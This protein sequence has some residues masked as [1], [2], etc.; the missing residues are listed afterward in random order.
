M[1]LGRPRRIDPRFSV[2]SRNSHAVLSPR[3]LVRAD[4]DWA[5]VAIADRRDPGCGN[6]RGDK[7]VL[8]GLSAALAEGE[9]VFARAALVAMT[10]DRHGDIRI[11]PQ[12]IG[13]TG[14]DLLRFRGDIRSVKGEEDAVARA[15]LQIL[16]R[17]RHDVPRTDAAGTRAPRRT[18]GRRLRRWAAASGKQQ[19][20]TQ[21]TDYFS[22]HI[23]PHL[24]RP[25]QY[26]CVVHR[27]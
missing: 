25:G 18:G 21:Q 13:L 10:F 24:D 15:R 6:P 5:F 20:S 1:P 27:S 9:I 19:Q 16:L 12:P 26:R 14:Q 23:N 22:M 7:D 3:F 4:D 8:G 11:T 17:T 2:D